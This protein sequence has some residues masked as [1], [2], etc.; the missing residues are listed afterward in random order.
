MNDT[1]LLKAIAGLRNE[2]Y[3]LQVAGILM[4]M[5]Q[6]DEADSREVEE[7]LR[8]LLPAGLMLGTSIPRDALF[9]KASGAGVPIAL[10]SRR[11]PAAS[12]VFDQLAAELE[13]KL[14]FEP[15]TQTPDG[16]TRLM[17]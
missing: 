11:P 12:L 17:D 14:D 8:E 5:V 3:R 1:G 4:T 7:E 13:R 15:I 16:I 10:L 2:G 9:L 6:E